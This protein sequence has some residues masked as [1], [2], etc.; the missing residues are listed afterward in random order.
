MLILKKEIGET[1]MI[2]DDIHVTVVEV[3]GRQVRLG[4]GAPRDVSIHR[5]EIS[6]KIKAEAHRTSDCSDAS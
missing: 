1:L 5:S 2:G 3:N 6:E 4:I